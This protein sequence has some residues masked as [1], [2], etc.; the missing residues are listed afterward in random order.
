MSVILLEPR[1][2]ISKFLLFKINSGNTEILLLPKLRN[3]RL[4]IFKKLSG[5]DLILFFLK[6]RYSSL[7]NLEIISI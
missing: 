3:R 6:L 2:R 7:E 4:F 1:N 5:I